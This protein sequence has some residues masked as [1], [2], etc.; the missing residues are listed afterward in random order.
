[1]EDLLSS[2]LSQVAD[3]DGVGDG[4][5]RGATAAA[6]LAVAMPRM[7]QGA[8]LCQICEKEFQ[9]YTCPQCQLLYCSLKCYKSEDHVSSIRPC[10]THT[11]THTHTHTPHARTH[12]HTCTRTRTRTRTSTRTHTRTHTHTHTH[13]P[14]TTHTCAYEHRQA[15]CSEGFYKAEFMVALKTK[16]AD[17]TE[18]RCASLPHRSAKPTRAHVLCPTMHTLCQ[19]QPQPQ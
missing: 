15:D 6:D 8:S 12:T 4:G 7:E 13:T 2:V 10:D 16:V 17:P 14:H 1:M 3:K 19:P 18:R 5:G 9:K 11:H